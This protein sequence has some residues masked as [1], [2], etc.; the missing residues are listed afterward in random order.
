MGHGD[1]DLSTVGHNGLTVRGVPAAQAQPSA[2]WE[3]MRQWKLEEER[4]FLCG[5][6]LSSALRDRKALSEVHQISAEGF[7]DR[8]ELF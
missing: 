7:S 8:R 3:N 2:P 1:F 6:S 4:S 5:A